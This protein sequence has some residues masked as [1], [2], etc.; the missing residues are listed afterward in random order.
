MAKVRH[1]TGGRFLNVSGYWEVF[2]PDYPAAVRMRGEGKRTHR[3]IGWVLEHRHAMEQF[4]GRELQPWENV[5]HKNGN[6]KDNCIEN[7]ELWVKTQPTGIRLKDIRDFYGA[8]SYGQAI[9]NARVA[10]SVPLWRPNQ[11]RHNAATLLRKRF[12]IET[13]RTILGHASGFTTEVYAELD[14]EKAKAVIKEVG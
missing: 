2:L 12:D 3:S 10:A 8:D 4:L 5:H 1:K 11:L 6:R 9:R 13:V 14:M 7:L